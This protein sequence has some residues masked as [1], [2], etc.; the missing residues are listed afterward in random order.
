M[1]ASGL[2][3]SMA[4]WHIIVTR[5]AKTYAASDG[6]ASGGVYSLRFDGE[7]ALWAA[8]EGG[9]SRLKDGHVATATSREW[10]TLPTCAMDSR[11]QCA[12]SVDDD[13]LRPGA[14]CT[15]RTQR[16]GRRFG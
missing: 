1:A 15:L 6:L 12:V 13:A 5:V 14:H 16:V 11:R 4:G 2:A 9:L 10:L 8:A 7:G 3:S